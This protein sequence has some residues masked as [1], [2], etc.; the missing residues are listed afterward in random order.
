MVT[1][2]RVLGFA[3]NSWLSSAAFGKVV[4]VEAVK[5]RSGEGRWGSFSLIFSLLERL[6]SLKHPLLPQALRKM[7]SDI[8]PL[9]EEFKCG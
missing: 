1:F 4:E 3:Y 9:R 8:F 2:Q 7:V 6:F 5:R